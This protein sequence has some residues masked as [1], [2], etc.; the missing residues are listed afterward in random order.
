WISFNT[1]GT[2]TFSQAGNVTLGA[3]NVSGAA[4]I[5]STGGTFTNSGTSYFLNTLSISSKGSLVF[6]A[7]INVSSGLTVDS[8]NGPTNLSVDSLSANLNGITPT[9]NG[10]ATNYTGPSQ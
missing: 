5:A 7:P 3:S 2:V 10:N 6:A 1:S 8:T 4:S 9:N